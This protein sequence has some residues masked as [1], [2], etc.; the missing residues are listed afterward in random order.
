MPV[1]RVGSDE[2]EGGDAELVEHSGILQASK[3]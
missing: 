2:L 1:Q 3:R